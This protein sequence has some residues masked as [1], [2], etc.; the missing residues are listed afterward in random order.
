MKYFI[1]LLFPFYAFGQHSIKIDSLPK[2]ITSLYQTAPFDSISITERQEKR[3]LELEQQSIMI[4][5]LQKEL[6]ADI[7]DRAGYEPAKIIP[8]AIKPKKLIIKIQKP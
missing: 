6:L 7:C 5:A 4:A 3:L 8:I 1:V 2:S